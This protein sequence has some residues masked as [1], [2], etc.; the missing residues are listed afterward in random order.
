MDP[1]LNGL[2]F[3]LENIA[4]V[5]GYFFISLVFAFSKGSL[6]KG[7]YRWEPPTSYGPHYQTRNFLRWLRCNQTRIGGLVFFF[8]CGCTHISLA[9][10]AAFAI[11]IIHHG[12]LSWYMHA[13]HIP[14]G[15]SVWLFVT[16]LVRPKKYKDPNESAAEVSRS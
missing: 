15:L 12:A 4:I 11:P 6:M 8:L 1:T 13:I 9:I 10:H 14:Q 7:L 3:Y 16:G 2:A 5:S